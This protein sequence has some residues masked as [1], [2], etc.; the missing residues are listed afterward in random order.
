MSLKKVCGPAHGLV[1]HI[2]LAVAILPCFAAG[3]YAQPV[4]FQFNILD[5]A[6]QGFNDPSLGPERLAALEFAGQYWGNLLPSTYAGETIHVNASFTAP[7]G[8]RADSQNIQ[9]FSNFS[10][11]SPNVCY[12]PALANHLAQTD[13]D[14]NVPEMAFRYNSAVPWY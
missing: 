3:A 11:L 4:P 14:S 2:A 12:G 10:G 8:V 6:G 9:V 5:P 13:L 7:S 1:R